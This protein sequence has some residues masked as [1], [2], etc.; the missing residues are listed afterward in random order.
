MRAGRGHLGRTLAGTGTIEFSFHG[1]L[2]IK[3]F[4]CSGFVVV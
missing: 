4:G 2:E 1:K 3:I